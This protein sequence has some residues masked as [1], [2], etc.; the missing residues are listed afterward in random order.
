[1][2]GKWHLDPNLQISDLL[3][4]EWDVYSVGKDDVPA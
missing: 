3:R 1:L 2:T 4:E